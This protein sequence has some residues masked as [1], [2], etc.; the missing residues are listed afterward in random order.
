MKLWSIANI[1]VL[2]W[3]VCI[4]LR[5]HSSHC[6]VSNNKAE[7]DD[8]LLEGHYVSLLQVGTQ[9]RLVP[10]TSSSVYSQSSAN[11]SNGSAF[12]AANQ[13]ESVPATLDLWDTLRL[14]PGKTGGGTVTWQLQQW[15]IG[16]GG[17]CHPEPCPN[18]IPNFRQTMISVRDPVDTFESAFNWR[19]WV[20]CLAENETRVPSSSDDAALEPWKFCDS[21][22][23]T[24]GEAAILHK[25]YA[26][27]ATHLAE[28]MCDEGRAGKEARQ[29]LGHIRHAKWPLT[30]W[31]SNES[32]QQTNLA[33]IVLEPGFDFEDQIVSVTKWAI[34]KNLGS[35]AANDMHDRR[36]S[37]NEQTPDKKRHSSQQSSYHSSP[38]SKLGQCCM[39]RHLAT[40]YELISNLPTLGCKG[41]RAN[42]CK[43]A[44][45]SIYTR[46][47]EFLNSSMSCQ[48][49]VSL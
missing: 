20:L 35:D 3:S 9:R 10:A 4:S 28:A 42:V 45:T 25:K 44:L 22:V 18:D 41:S 29:D 11:A 30:D 16:M 19:A 48:E 15:K 7:G 2:V 37:V 46:R 36:K 6:S 12:H 40:S 21:G 24:P 38:L 26:F 14:H 27:N 1:V 13:K 49:F 8:S 34:K 43:A 31:L 39:A 47:Q 33:A 23:D 17:S 5:S 32:L